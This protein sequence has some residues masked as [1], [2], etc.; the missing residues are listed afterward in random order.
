MLNLKPGRGT[1][2]W[3]NGKNAQE[4]LI[5][6]PK[7]APADIYRQIMMISDTLLTS[8]QNIG[9]SSKKGFKVISP[10]ESAY[11]VMNTSVVD[12]TLRFSEDPKTHHI[13]YDPYKF[14]HE[15]HS[16]YDPNEFRK[17]HPVP[18][19]YMDTL[20]K[21][22]SVKYTY[23]KFNYIFVR[24][25][26]GI[27]LQVHTLREERWEI[28]QGHP[29]IIAG[30]KVHFDVNPGQK[31]SMSLGSMHTVINPS[32]SEWVLLKEEYAGQFDEKDIVRVFNPNNYY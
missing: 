24:P 28:L 18:D 10:A 6:V 2:L 15:D 16:D 13:L 3:M 23:P 20:P 31:F 25:G 32:E 19:G 30:P 4:V 21:W 17:A 29:I 14:E 8:V 9:I 22:Y 7:T 27:S 1:P 12:L 26:L 5:Q 11:M